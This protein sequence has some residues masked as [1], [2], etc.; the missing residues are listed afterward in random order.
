[1]GKKKRKIVLEKWPG[2]SE[3][4]YPAPLA[5]T[6]Q[7][8]SPGP[9][10]GAYRLRLPGPRGSQGWRNRIQDI[11]D[12][13]CNGAEGISQLTDGFRTILLLHLP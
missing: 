4:G 12:G 8:P 3:R 1:M 2:E 13:H 10:S 9:E 6:Q 5:S 11:L 7:V